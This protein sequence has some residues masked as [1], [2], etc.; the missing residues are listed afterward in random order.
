[1][2]NPAN[3]LKSVSPAAVLGE[4]AAA[5]PVDC[6]DKIIVIGI[7]PQLIE[8]TNTKRSNKDLGR[9]LAI[10]RLAIARNEDALLEWPELWKGA[11]QQSFPDE[12]RA[13]AGRVGQGVRALLASESDL[14]QALLTCVN[15]LLASRPPTLEQFRIAGQRLLQDAIDPIETEVV[16]GE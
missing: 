12:W 5:V 14:E 15:G 9:V 8:G 11:L 1:M 6:R 16:A 2:A 13:L 10:A 3:G 4:I 7:H